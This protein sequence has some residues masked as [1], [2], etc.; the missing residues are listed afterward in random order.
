M[1]A[2]LVFGTAVTDQVLAL[3]RMPIGAPIP[4]ALIDSRWARMEFNGHCKD[5]P[6]SQQHTRQAPTSRQT[7]STLSMSSIAQSPTCPAVFW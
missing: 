3:A 6:P 7:S 1:E 5:H 2:S 4:H